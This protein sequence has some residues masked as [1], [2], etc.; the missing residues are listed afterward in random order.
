MLQLRTA[1]QKHPSNTADRA[2]VSGMGQKK[3]LGAEN[4]APNHDL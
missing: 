2:L 1:L 3:W 4:K